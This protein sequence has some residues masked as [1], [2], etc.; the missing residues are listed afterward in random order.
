MAV[1]WQNDSPVFLRRLLVALRIEMVRPWNLLTSHSLLSVVILLR[2]VR[3]LALFWWLLW[4]R[5]ITM[6]QTISNSNHTQN[7]RGVLAL[8]L[9]H[10]SLWFSKP[11]GDITAWKHEDQ[12]WS[13]LEQK[14]INV[15]GFGKRYHLSQY[16]NNSYKAKQSSG[17]YFGRKRIIAPFMSVT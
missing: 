11:L 8:F 9:V 7:Y 15:S 2:L 5:S 4:G 3:H 6:C 13:S 1:C 10:V 14:C 17:W 16:V 12:N